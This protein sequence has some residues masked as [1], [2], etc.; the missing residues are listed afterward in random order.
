MISNADRSGNGQSV[1]LEEYFQII[2]N[3]TWIWCSYVKPV[4]SVS[5]DKIATSHSTRQTKDQKKASYNFVLEPSL[6]KL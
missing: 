6:A 3:S 4:Q 2:K 5:D 1:G